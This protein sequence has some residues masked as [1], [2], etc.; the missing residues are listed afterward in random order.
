MFCILCARFFEK[1]NELSFIDD[2]NYEKLLNCFKEEFYNTITKGF[3]LNQEGVTVRIASS[4]NPESNR[5]YKNWFAGLKNDFG[6]VFFKKNNYEY[7]LL[8]SNFPDHDERNKIGVCGVKI[9][10]S[11][12][13][14]LATQDTSVYSTSMYAER[15][16]EEITEP[17]YLN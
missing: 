1:M 11:G 15:E 17:N 4:Y 3:R 2:R 10:K 14:F 5:V 16:E 13:P 8:L 6:S 12:I 9:F 7:G